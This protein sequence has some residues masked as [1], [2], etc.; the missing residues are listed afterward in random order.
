VAGVVVGPACSRPAG[1]SA[2]PGHSNATTSPSPIASP[3]TSSA[4]RGPYRSLGGGPDRPRRHHPGRGVPAPTGDLG[5]GGRRG[6]RPARARARLACRWRAGSAGRAAWPGRSAPPRPTPGSTCGLRQE[7]G[8][9]GSLTCRA[10]DRHLRTVRPRPE[11]RAAGEQLV[12]H[13]AQPVQVRAG[14]HR[15]TLGVR[16]GQRRTHLDGKLGGPPG[17]QPAWRASSSARLGGVCNFYLLEDGGRLV[18]VDAGAPCCCA[19]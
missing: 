3:A 17:R 8:W 1:V 5:A 19:P 7:G 16:G 18:L 13:T 4:Q 14:I 9:G 10:G 15:P 6:P 2:P 11:R 12:Q